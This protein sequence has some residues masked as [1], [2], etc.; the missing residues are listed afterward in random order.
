MRRVVDDDGAG[1]NVA[2]PSGLSDT[3]AAAVT[4][5]IGT[6]AVTIKQDHIVYTRSATAIAASVDTG[7]PLSVSSS[8][9]VWSFSL[10]TH[11]RR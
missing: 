4:A 6:I 10:L 2:F 9:S 5:V 8:P 7:T 1:T 3:N 11:H